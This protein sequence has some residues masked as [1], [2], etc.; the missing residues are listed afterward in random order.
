MSPW[1]ALPEPGGCDPRPVSDSLDGM[2][3]HLGAPRAS[4]L[5]AVFARWEEVVGSSIAAHAEPVSV[6][7]NVLVIA[8]EEPG[9]ATQLR[10]LGPGLLRRLSAVAGVDS[11]DR[12]EIK[13]RPPG[14][15]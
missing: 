7:D 3:R 6:R 10:F 14:R 8:T 5:H 9:W 1:R 4:V 15:R 13:V 11:I 12:V 2:T